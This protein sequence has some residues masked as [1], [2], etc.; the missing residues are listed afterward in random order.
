M[1]SFV[2]QTSL[3]A[4]V[5]MTEV[6]RV[7][8]GNFLA[9]YLKWAKFKE[10]NLKSEPNYSSFTLVTSNARASVALILPTDSIDHITWQVP[11]SR[12]TLPT[13]LH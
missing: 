12:W 5:K 9:L 2:I 8:Q 6:Y 13:E 3:H 1:S 4:F 7:S 10:I 11:T